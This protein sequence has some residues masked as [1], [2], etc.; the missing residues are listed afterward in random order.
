MLYQDILDNVIERIKDDIRKEQVN[1]AMILSQ[2]QLL[3][4]TCLSTELMSYKENSSSKL[5]LLLDYV[6]SIGSDKLV[7]FCFF[8]NPFPQFFKIG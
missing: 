3:I 1:F 2:C 6:E 8:T 7:I 4:Q 5:S